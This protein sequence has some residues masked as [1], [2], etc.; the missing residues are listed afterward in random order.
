M[1]ADAKNSNR[2]FDHSRGGNPRHRAATRLSANR[3]EGLVALLAAAPSGEFG[4]VLVDDLSRLARDNHLML[5]II[6]ELHFEGIHVIS[7][8]D[9]LD[10]TDEE[11][12]L[13]IQVR[14]SST[15]FNSAT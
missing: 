3:R 2:G 10:S 12:T 7:V 5:S 4:V 1:D 9:G 15:S 14:A 8:A 13:A 11:S 6:A